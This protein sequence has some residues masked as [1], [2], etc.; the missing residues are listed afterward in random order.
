MPSSDSDRRNT[1]E[2]D[3]H[4]DATLAADREG[5]DRVRRRADSQHTPSHGSPPRSS[6]TPGTNVKARP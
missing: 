2:R 5:R 4:A 6:H 3:R 1:R